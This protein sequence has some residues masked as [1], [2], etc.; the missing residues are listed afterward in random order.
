[1][2][3]QF[4]ALALSPFVPQRLTTFISTQKLADIE[5]LARL[6]A[7]GRL[8]IPLSRSYPLAQAPAAVDQLSAGRARGK[9]AVT[10]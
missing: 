2:G 3:A 7:D 10:G 5:E 4:R 1:M 8:T 6:A 9:I